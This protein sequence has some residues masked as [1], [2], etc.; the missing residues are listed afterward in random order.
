MSLGSR[1]NPPQLVSG[2]LE[3]AREGVEAIEVME[4]QAAGSVGL[5]E[6]LGDL[7]FCVLQCAIGEEE[8]T[9]DLADVARNSREN[10]ASA[11]TFS[12][13]PDTPMPSKNSGTMESHKGCGSDKA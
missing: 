10:G 1:A 4:T 5:V 8:G 6:E 9:F 7:L 3:E 2:L 11:S 13:A 12:V